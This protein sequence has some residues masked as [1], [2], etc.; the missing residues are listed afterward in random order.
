MAKLRCIKL[1][2]SQKNLLREGLLVAVIFCLLLAIALGWF[3]SNKE[4]GAGGIQLSAQVND[5]IA[6]LYEFI[7]N[8]KTPSNPA[9]ASQWE[10]VDKIEIMNYLPGE[11][12]TYKIVLTN[13]STVTEHTCS[14]T[15]AGFGYTVNVNN[16]SNDP[17]TPATY[18]GLEDVIKLSDVEF[19]S[20]STTVG[21][22]ATGGGIL[23]SYWTGNK[24]RD[25]ELAWEIV[26]PKKSES[27]ADTNANTA[28]IQFTFAL[29]GETDNF[30]QNQRLTFDKIEIATA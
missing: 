19:T 6:E 7:D 30:H 23:S 15:L 8:T 18:K 20:S 2:D 16:K 22:S 12:R 10:K 13:Q 24:D 17:S 14:V 5:V 9:D 25:I 3:T 21:T 11:N 4:V 29:P 28:T 26:V 27:E 1:T